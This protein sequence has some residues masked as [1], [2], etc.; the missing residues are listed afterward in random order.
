MRK[1]PIF[2]SKNLWSLAMQILTLSH[3]GIQITLA[4]LSQSCVQGQH[5]SAIIMLVAKA[6]RTIMVLIDFHFN[7]WYH[8]V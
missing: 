4:E 5:P 7:L 3:G 6:F 2:S 1:Q 8:C